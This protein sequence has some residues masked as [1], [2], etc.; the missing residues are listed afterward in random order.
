MSNIHT[1]IQ[2]GAPSFTAN[3]MLGTFLPL[4][5]MIGVF[6][7]GLIRPQKKKEKKIEEMRESLGVG[8]EIVTI[9]GITGKVVQVKKDFI[10]IETSGMKTRI[11]L[12]KWSIQSVTKSRGK[13]DF[14][15]DEVETSNIENE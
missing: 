5:L 1:L 15:A 8:D 3:S 10:L 13:K 2:L 11:E 9:G 6:Y 4:I 7:F 14:V 12:M